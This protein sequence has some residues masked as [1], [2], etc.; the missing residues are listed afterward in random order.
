[1]GIIH[2]D[3]KASNLMLHRDVDVAGIIA[4]F[5]SRYCYILVLCYFR[6]STA[7]ARAPHGFW[8]VCHD[9]EGRIIYKVS[10][11]QIIKLCTYIG[12]IYRT[13]HTGTP[14][15][16]APELLAVVTEADSPPPEARHTHSSS[17][18]PIT[19]IPSPL[20][21]PTVPASEKASEPAW[22]SYDAKC[23]IWSLGL[24]LYFMAYGQL[25]WTASR[26]NEEDLNRACVS[27]LISIEFFRGNPTRPRA[28][29]R[30][31]EPFT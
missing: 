6:I 2:R 16:V 3:I 28:L 10:A 24:V 31:S 8:H 15:W 20:D 26:E 19:L 23:D 5:F 22:G 13:G 25:P 7:T 30:H 21:D 14:E 9:G 17:P 12:M 1:M 29:A 18:P 4:Y 11:L 27:F